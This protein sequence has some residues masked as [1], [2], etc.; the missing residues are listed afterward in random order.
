[1]DDNQLPTD[2]RQLERELAGRP[3]PGP[4]AELRRRVIDGARVELRR[5]G[6]RNGWPLAAAVAAAV[7]VWI[8]LSM[9]A[10]LGTDYGPG[11]DTAGPPA[12]KVAAQIRQLLPELSENDAL[13]QAVLLQS[14]SDLTLHPSVPAGPASLRPLGDLD[15]LL[16]Q[17]E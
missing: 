12:G 2:L 11:P 14:R 13:L 1:M 16:P 5:N 15:A 10:T 8:N 4:P 7:V 3:R 17:G 9:S 6:S